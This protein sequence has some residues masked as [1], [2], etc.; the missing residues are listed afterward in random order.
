M[1]KEFFFYFMDKEYNNIKKRNK[2]DMLQLYTWSYI[3]C[4]CVLCKGN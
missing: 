3:A 4:V 1:I 2:K